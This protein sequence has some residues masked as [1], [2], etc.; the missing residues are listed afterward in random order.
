LESV[1]EP[2]KEITGVCTRR[3]FEVAEDVN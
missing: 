3:G 2:G 1:D